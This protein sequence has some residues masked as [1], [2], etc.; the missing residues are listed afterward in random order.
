MTRLIRL[1]HMTNDPWSLAN[2]VVLALLLTGRLRHSPRHQH[3]D[4]ADVGNVG[5]R[6]QSVVHQN[7]LQRT[8]VAVRKAN[9]TSATNTLHRHHYHRQVTSSR[10]MITCQMSTTRGEHCRHRTTVPCTSKQPF[11]RAKTR[12]YKLVIPKRKCAVAD[13]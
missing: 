8:R 2:A 7:I 12:R 4:V 1:E 10:P 3:D 6:A 9:L 13:Y 5:D 11:F